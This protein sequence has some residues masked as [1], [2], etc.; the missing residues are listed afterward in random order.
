M[1]NSTF[2]SSFQEGFNVVK[3]NSSASLVSISL[4]PKATAHCPGGLQST[5]VHDSQWRV[6]RDSMLLNIPV[7]LHVRTRRIHG[8]QCGVRRETIHWLE[9]F[10][11]EPN[12]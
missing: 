3:F 1:T 7:E 11:I 9:P 6:I 2:L 8:R 12:G 4:E 5:S 10:S